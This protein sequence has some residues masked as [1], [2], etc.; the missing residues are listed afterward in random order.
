M[1]SI[2]IDN[3]LSNAI[4]DVFL[5]GASNNNNGLNMTAP[6]L[7]RKV[8]VPVVARTPAQR[9]L[10]IRF[11]NPDKFD[12]DTPFKA[13]EDFEPIEY[14][15]PRQRIPVAKSDK[16]AREQMMYYVQYILEQFRQASSLF[17]SFHASGDDITIVFDCPN[18]F[19]VAYDVKLYCAG[20]WMLSDSNISRSYH[21]STWG[22]IDFAILDMLR[23]AREIISSTFKQ[24]L[25]ACDWH[26]QKG[27]LAFVDPPKK[28]IRSSE[29]SYSSSD[30]DDN[31]KS[32]NKN[33]NKVR[34]SRNSRNSRNSSES[35]SSSD[36][37]ETE[38]SEISEN[39][40]SES[41]DRRGKKKNNKTKK[42]SKGSKRK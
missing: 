5:A 6:V 37:S 22:A 35:E 14:Q 24:P 26:E 16:R 15:K 23:N 36:N 42:P 8:V 38:E 30:D 25:N 40:I 2:A 17:S 41:E 13:S 19:S 4:N 27:V 9:R 28:N 32:K 21:F 39:E 7:A 1:S 12:D 3:A 34:H 33:K 20:D 29:S 31:N 18:G 11:D 10:L